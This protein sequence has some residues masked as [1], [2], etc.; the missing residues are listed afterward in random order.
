M[1]RVVIFTMKR[2]K[3]LEFSLCHCEEDRMD[4][5]AI[6]RASGDACGVDGSIAGSQWI[7]TGF[8]PRDDNALF[9]HCEED[10]MDDAAIHPVLG[11]ADGFVCS[12]IGSQWIATPQEARDDKGGIFTMKGG[13]RLEF[14][15][16]HCKEGAGAREAAIHRVSG[17]VD[18]VVCSGS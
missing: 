16:C 12:F 7:A 10:S 18:G 11:D 9:C 1:T 6:H 17:D 8:R 5:A 14:S 15:H 4:D 3:R 2:M 13:K